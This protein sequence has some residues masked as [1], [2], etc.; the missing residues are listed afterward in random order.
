M[1]ISEIDRHIIWGGVV[2][3]NILGLFGNLNVI[4]A[5]Y[6]LKALR[7]KYGILLTMLVTV[8]SICLIYELVGTVYGVFVRPIIRKT[9]FYLISPYIVTYCIQMGLMAAISTDLLISIAAPLRHRAF[10][11][12]KYLSMLVIPGVIYGGVVLTIGIFYADSEEIK[13]CQPPSSLPFSV[14]KVWYILA[15]IFNAITTISYVA[16]FTIIYCKYREHHFDRQFDNSHIERKAM[17]SLSVLIIVFLL[18]RLL[19]IFLM[20]VLEAAGFSVEVIE[21]AQA[22]MAFSAMACYSSTFYVCFAR[23]SEYR[24]IFWSQIVDTVGCCGV[25][26]KEDRFGS[27]S[28]DELRHTCFYILSP[29]IFTFCLQVALMAA[30]STDMLISIAFPLQHRMLRRRTYLTILVLPGVIYGVAVLITGVIFTN[31]RQ[32]KLCNLPTSLPFKVMK[33]WHLAGLVFTVVTIFSYLAAYAILYRKYKNNINH[34]NVVHFNQIAKLHSDNKN[35]ER[36]ALK[37][38]SIL[39]VVF[40]IE[41]L[42]FISLINY[43]DF[44][45]HSKDVLEKA[46][47]YMVFSSLTVYSSTYYVCF[48]RSSEYRRIFWRQIV[49]MIGCFGVKLQEDR[50]GH[51]S[52][53]DLS[54]VVVFNIFGLFGNLNVIYAHYR[55]K[56]LRNTLHNVGYGSLNLSTKWVFLLRIDLHLHLLHLMSLMAAISVDMFF[57]I[58]APL[59]HRMLRRRTYLTVLMTPGIIYGIS[60]VLMGHVIGLV[61]IMTTII[62]YISAFAVIYR[63][64][65]VHCVCPYDLSF[66][67]IQFIQFSTGDIERNA[68]KS[69]SIIIIVFICERLIFIFLMNYLDFSRYS[70]E[71][72]DK[73]EAYMIFSALTVYSSTFYVCFARSIVAVSLLFSA[74]GRSLLGIKLNKDRFARSSTAD[75]RKN[76]ESRND[77]FQLSSVETEQK[78]HPILSKHRFGMDIIS[79]IIGL[80]AKKKTSF[81]SSGD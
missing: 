55:L 21:R 20:N 81:F 72:M 56:E 65:R 38:L 26:L 69:L 45:G 23:S 3:F 30:I 47:A 70:K 58:A 4:Y 27:S 12:K 59:W 50:F 79:S 16:A 54:G 68:M 29:Y 74:S 22:Y 57:S 52:T 71:V 19:L 18:E 10:S 7:T 25:K 35:I 60:A 80:G 31:E 64:Y 36:K 44:A 34:F 9:C 78:T 8:Q 51:S 41:R 5:H 2:I 46:Q 24:K 62:F 77:K 39:I 1:A 15:L 53:E 37:S 73:A 6:R 67:L 42:F 75:L 76:T 61:F 63:K 32:L 13:L 40:I 11:T 17:K 48:A 43:L 33:M 28:I 49:K 14:R 66:S